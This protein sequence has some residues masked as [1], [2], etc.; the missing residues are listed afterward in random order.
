MSQHHFWSILTFFTYPHKLQNISLNLAVLFFLCSQ[1]LG[2]YYENKCVKDFWVTL[3]VHTQIT[4]TLLDAVRRLYSHLVNHKS[5][6]EATELDGHKVSEIRSEQQKSAFIPLCLSAAAE[7]LM[8]A[9]PIQ[10]KQN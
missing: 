1:G 8:F 6:A 3:S 7:T 2:I 9:L 5:E 4:H 10:S